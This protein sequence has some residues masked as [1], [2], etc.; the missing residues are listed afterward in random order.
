MGAFFKRCCLF[1]NHRIMHNTS[2]KNKVSVSMEFFR[3]PISFWI[4]KSIGNMKFSERFRFR[5]LTQGNPEFL[6]EIESNKFKF[7]I[8]V[9]FLGFTFFHNL[10]SSLVN[11]D[12]D[13]SQ[14]KSS[15]FVA[16]WVFIFKP[17]RIFFDDLVFCEIF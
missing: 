15:S 14:F 17:I 11:W 9:E 3:F 2:S 13:L 8:F 7:L 6:P 12:W 4:I 5:F 1:L 10:S 16:I